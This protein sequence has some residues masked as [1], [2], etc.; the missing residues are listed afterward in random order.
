MSNNNIEDK[1][2]LEALEQLKLIQKVITASNTLTF[3]GKR[4]IVVGILLILT[5]FI[6]IGIG[7]TFW[8]IPYFIHGNESLGMVI[9]VLIYFVIFKAFTY[10][11]KSEECEMRKKN[12][13]NPT[14]KKLF[15]VHNVIIWTMIALIFALAFFASS[16]Y[17]VPTVLIFL[18]L[19]FNVFGRLTIK[20]IL[21][22][23]YSYIVLGIFYICLGNHFAEYSWMIAVIYM[24][25]SYVVMGIQMNKK[26]RE[27]SHAE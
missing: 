18:G 25:I 23:S 7:K 24:G 17:I 1:E 11:Y 16:L 6:Q 20:S 9:N 15:D 2:K 14:L 27:I 21:W 5:P 8:K 22:I 12:T 4:L 26:S 13:M 19:L 10:T 3:S